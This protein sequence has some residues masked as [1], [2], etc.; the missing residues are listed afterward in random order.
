MNLEE[1][2]FHLGV[3]T[4]IQNN[5]G[6]L[7][8]LQLDPKKFKNESK[9]DIPGGRIKKNESV[10]NTLK[11]EVYEETGLQNI[12]FLSPLTMVLS[13]FRLT[14]NTGNVGLILAVYL[15]QAP[16]PCPIQLSGEH[17]HFGWF[18]P[19]EA[20][21]MLKMNHAPELIEKITQIIPKH[22]LKN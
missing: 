8:L 14:T 6:K 1:D 17:V 3:K 11:R 19:K 4:L 18:S 20:A 16:D 9:W 7:L 2:C 12:T 22:T 5:H 15:C 13:P 21:E 10:E